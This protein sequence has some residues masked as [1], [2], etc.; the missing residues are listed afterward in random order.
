[1]KN[2][3]QKRGFGN[4]LLLIGLLMFLVGCQ[5]AAEK[6]VTEMATVLPQGKKIADY[7]LTSYGEK[8]FGNDS[9]LGKWTLFFFG[10]TRCP[11]V[12]PTELYMLAEL[13]RRI[14]QNSALVTQ[15]PQVVFVSV[16]PQQDK[17]EAL[18]D[19]VRFYHPSIL[20]ITGKQS[21]V[22]RLSRAM[23]AFHE[24]VYHQNGEVI[25]LDTE[26][27]I[28]VGLENS[29]LVNHSATI[30]LVNPEGDL[31]AVF[32]APHDPDVMLRDLAAI[33]SAWR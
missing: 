28:P 14:D 9:T 4:F 16:D 15:A 12:C 7:Q 22:D 33:Q 26:D 19:Y 13:I 31:H 21:D 23:G 8:D 29:Y 1:M 2:A 24:R 30:F 27:E 3:T 25:A 6:P 20:G 32:S 18:R 17:P 10:Y 5:R 11:D